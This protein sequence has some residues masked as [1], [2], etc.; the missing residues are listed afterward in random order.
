[1]LEIASTV[2]QQC[3]NWVVN[4]IWFYQIAFVEL[5]LGFIYQNQVMPV[6]CDAAAT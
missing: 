5:F 2:Q 1:M 3:Q 4:T 6:Y